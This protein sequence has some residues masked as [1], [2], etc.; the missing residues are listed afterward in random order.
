MGIKKQINCMFR[1]GSQRLAFSSWRQVAMGLLS[2]VLGRF[3]KANSSRG[4]DELADGWIQ[5]LSVLYLHF[6]HVVIDIAF[7]N[8]GCFTAYCQSAI[9]QG[10]ILQREGNVSLKVVLN[11]HY[12]M[13]G[14]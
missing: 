10:P 14:L 1:A 11:C 13:P 3:G 6:L 2:L 12:A 4:S 7:C 5:L 9:H 8:R